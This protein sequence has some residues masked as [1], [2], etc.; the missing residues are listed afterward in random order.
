M[1]WGRED[2]RV[3]KK[4]DISG[5]EISMCIGRVAMVTALKARIAKEDA[6]RSL[7]IKFSWPGVSMWTKQVQ[8]KTREGR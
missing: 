4:G 6:P 7:S 8:L 1:R 3:L 2:R 5:N